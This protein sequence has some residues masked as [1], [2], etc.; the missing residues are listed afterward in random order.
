MQKLRIKRIETFR[1]NK[2][3]QY[4]LR[5]IG[6]NGRTVIP[7]EGYTRKAGRDN[8]VAIINQSLLTAVPVVQ[9][10]WVKVKGLKKEVLRPARALVNQAKAAAKASQARKR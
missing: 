9:M 6:L 4:Y 10:E 1:S 8:A 2:N 3:N 5:A 7:S